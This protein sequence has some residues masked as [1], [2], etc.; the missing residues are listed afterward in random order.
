[1]TQTF[2]QIYIFS[3]KQIRFP[4]EEYAPIGNIFSLPSSPMY[5]DIYDFIISKRTSN[6]N[7]QTKSDEESHKSVDTRDGSSSTWILSYL[8]FGAEAIFMATSYIE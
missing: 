6:D 2:L 5:L 8:L 1:M 7:S 3:Y 4:V